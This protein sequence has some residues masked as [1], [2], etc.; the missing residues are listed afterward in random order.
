[1]GMHTWFAVL[2]LTIGASNAWAGDMPKRLACDAQKMSDAAAICLLLE[3]NMAFE[4][5]GHATIAPGY[6]VSFATIRKVWCAR[7]FT[8]ADLPALAQLE[9]SADWRLQTGA[10]ALR[11]LIEKTPQPRNSVY[12]PDNSSYVL[13]NG[14]Q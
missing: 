9:K 14:C 8:A 1:M 3:T 13:R 7:P 4:W 5:L 11:I 10:S 2:G 6:R 12:N